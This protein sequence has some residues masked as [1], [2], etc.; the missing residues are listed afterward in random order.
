MKETRVTNSKPRNNRAAG[1]SFSRDTPYMHSRSEDIQREMR[2]ERWQKFPLSSPR[3]IVRSGNVA[4]PV[5]ARKKPSFPSCAGHDGEFAGHPS[6]ALP[7]VARGIGNVP[8]R[9]HGIDSSPREFPA[10][11]KQEE[12]RSTAIRDAR[13]RLYVKWI[14]QRY[15]SSRW[16]AFPSPCLPFIRRFVVVF[17]EQDRP[18]TPPTKGALSGGANCLLEEQVNR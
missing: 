2:R 13:R 6:G 10:R 5:V 16:I 7:D 17:S 1:Q 3:D 18:R 8:D 9:L 4:G 14:R 15:A 12:R 11:K